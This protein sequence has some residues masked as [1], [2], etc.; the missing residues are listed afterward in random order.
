MGLIN[1]CRKILNYWRILKSGFFFS[2]T[3]CVEIVEPSILPMVFQDV[4]LKRNDRYVEHIYCKICWAY[5]KSFKNW[6]QRRWVEITG[7]RVASRVELFKSWDSL[8]NLL[9][10]PVK[11]WLPELNCL[12]L[13][14]H[15]VTCESQSSLETERSRRN[16]CLGLRLVFHTS[17]L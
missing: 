4:H 14:E 13:S 3:F 17:F 10:S 2:D 5:C 16:K 6:K 8:L 1:F 11:L 7:K 9:L 15:S 12:R